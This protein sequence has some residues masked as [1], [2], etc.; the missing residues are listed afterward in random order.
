MRFL[1]SLVF[2]SCLSAQPVL[3][4]TDEPGAWPGMFDAVGLSLRQASDLP[5][6]VARER[7]QAGAVGILEGS[8][9]VAEGFGIKPTSKKVVVRSVTD[10][11]LAETRHH[12]GK[13]PGVARLRTPLRC[14]NF[15]KGALDGRAINGRTQA[16]RRIGFLARDQTWSSWIRTLPVCASGALRSRS[17]AASSIQQAVG[18]L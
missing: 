2:A 9:A 6:A 12:L 18:L 11:A 17:A 1:V 10:A 7:I 15:R 14:S 16:R 5:P 13:G 3:L 8:S 4:L